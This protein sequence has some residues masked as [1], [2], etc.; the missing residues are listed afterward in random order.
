MAQ[1]TA[2]PW[3]LHLQGELGLTYL[4]RSTKDSGGQN[5]DC[6]L[7]RLTI[8]L[9]GQQGL[10]CSICKVSYRDNISMKVENKRSGEDTEGQNSD[11]P[12]ESLTISLKGQQGLGCSICKVSYRDNISMKAKDRGQARTL[13]AKTVTVLW[14]V[15]PSLSRDSR[16]S[17]A[18]FAR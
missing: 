15:S 5:S 17:A 11:C 18:P 12:L 8:S 16:A 13:E 7:E 14:R 6:P 2:G 10:G 9:K 3:L 1:G 4:W